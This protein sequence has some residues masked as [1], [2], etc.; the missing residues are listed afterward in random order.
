MN[1]VA[2]GRPERQVP[3]SAM[4]AGWRQG[5]IVG[6]HGKRLCRWA[7]EDSR[8]TSWGGS[9]VKPTW[10]WSVEELP[11]MPSNMWAAT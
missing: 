3:W 10:G 2:A 6:S 8:I 11:I 5:D 9:T 1:L 4:G 7:Q